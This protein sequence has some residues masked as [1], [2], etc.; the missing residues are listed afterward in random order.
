VAAVCKV[1]A[2]VSHLG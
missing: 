2:T 1:K